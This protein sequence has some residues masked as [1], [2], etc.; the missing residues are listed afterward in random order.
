MGKMVATLEMT[1]ELIE[2]L[3]I[4]RKMAREEFESGFGFYARSTRLDSVANRVLARL[5]D[6]KG[7]KSGLFGPA[8]F[9]PLPGNERI[10]GLVRRSVKPWPVAL[11]FALATLYDN[12]KRVVYPWVPT[13]PVDEND[14]YTRNEN[15]RLLGL[16]S[17]VFEARADYADGRLNTEKFVASGD[18]WSNEYRMEWCYLWAMDCGELRVNWNTPVE[19]RDWCLSL[20]SLG[21]GSGFVVSDYD[22]KAVMAKAE[23]DRLARKAEYEAE[24][25]LGVDAMS[26]LREGKLMDGLTVK[27]RRCASGWLAFSLWLGEKRMSAGVGEL[28]CDGPEN[29]ALCKL[30]E[31]GSLIPGCCDTY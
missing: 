11:K 21:F 1:D 10:F 23:A 6:K 24:V 20:R 7:Y 9:E 22:I 12:E 18:R 3:S 8:L 16:R 26:A 17:L 5:T 27:V 13:E 4:A 25:K 19:M 14:R 28:N 15:E 30:I 31:D 29:L 2:M